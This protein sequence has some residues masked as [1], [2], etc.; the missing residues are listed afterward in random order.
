MG[1]TRIWSD[2]QI[3]DALA[4][5]SRVGLRQAAKATGIPFGTL[6]RWQAN[7]KRDKRD[8]TGKTA[9]LAQSVEEKT[10][11]V[12]AA[13]GAA[14]AEPGGIGEKAVR[15]ADAL[16]NLAEK[17]RGQLDEALDEAR[18]PGRKKPDDRWARVLVGVL[19]QSL[20][21]AQLLSGRPTGRAVIDGS[22]VHTA[23]VAQ[24]MSDPEAVELARLLFRR[25]QPTEAEP[26]SD[27]LVQ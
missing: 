22:V 2:E 4:L 12:D 19:A 23:D 18:R 27:R 24:I 5:A 6:G 3:S 11:E 7:L 1:K 17:A 16:Y 13:I 25:S 8:E 21:K 26:E 20:E 14:V 15:M 10:A 9:S